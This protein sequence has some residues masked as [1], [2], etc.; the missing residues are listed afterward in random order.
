MLS[1]GVY[2]LK[3][4]TKD[5][6]FFI[7]AITDDRMNKQLRFMRRTARAGAHPRLALSS[8]RERILETLP[9]SPRNMHE[10]QSAVTVRRS[11]FAG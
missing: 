9:I 5:G 3:S 2:K 6:R 1:Q 10:M 7:F 11:K 4:A 8:Q